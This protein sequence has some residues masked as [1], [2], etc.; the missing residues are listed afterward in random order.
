MKHLWEILKKE[1]IAQEVDLTDALKEGAN[2]KDFEEAEKIMGIKFPIDFKEFYKIH[3]GQNDMKTWLIYEQE[4]LSL[5]RIVSEWKIWKDLYDKKTFE[6]DGIPYTSS[7]D[8][9][10]KD[11]WWNP[12]WIPITYD[13]CG[14]HYCI[15][16]D[17]DKNGKVGQIITMYHDDDI[18]D[19][20]SNSFKEFIEKYIDDLKTGN[21]I[22]EF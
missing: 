19:L 5:K 11:V 17:P 2:E 4:F 18:R 14:N 6:K 10:V 12:K 16:F 3:N 20:V 15:D 1:L 21:F 8:E 13:G 9:G 7:A 22:F